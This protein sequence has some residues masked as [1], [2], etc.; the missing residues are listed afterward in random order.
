MNSLIEKA[1]A[2][3]DAGR[4]EEAA[5]LWQQVAEQAAI[6]EVQCRL[7]LAL[8]AINR[9]SQ[10]EA[11][12]LRAIRLDSSSAEAMECLGLL[13]LER[14]DLPEN[15]RLGE[16]LRWFSRALKFERTARVLNF[17]GATHKALE[18]RDAARRNFEQAIQED[19]EYAEALYNLAGLEEDNDPTNATAHLERAL[20]VDPSYTAA[21][22]KLGTLLQKRKD[23][24]VAE[25]HFRRSIEADALNVWSHLYL[26]NLLA[27]MGANA[28]AEREYRTA[29]AIDGNDPDIRRFF[30]T[31]LQGLSRNEEASRILKSTPPETT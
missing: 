3:E 31:F 28:E 6:P 14:S 30:A 20:Q 26:A 2:A 19:G 9:W 24:V 13:G 21:H 17:L 23:F 15:E 27:T 16:S 10:A 25:Y 5:S 11:A 7:G 29:L 22:E 18:D 4:L 8:Q 1:E 12:F